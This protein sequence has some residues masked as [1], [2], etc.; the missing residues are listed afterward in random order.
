[1]IKKEFADMIASMADPRLVD[2][3]AII[4]QTPPEV[5]VRL[6][7][8]KST[9]ATAT[10][11]IAEC[12][13]CGEV[14]WWPGGRYLPRRPKFTLDPALHQGVY[15]VQ[16]ASSMIIATVAGKLASLISDENLKGGE[17]SSLPLLWLDACAAPGGKT[18]AAIDA[19]PAGSLVVANEYDYQRAEILKENVVKWG[20]PDMVVS[21]GDTSRFRKLPDLFD[22]VAV[23]APCSGEGM[24]RKDEV[25]RRQWTPALVAECADRQRQ[26]LGNLWE[27]VRPGGYLVYSTCTFNTA[28]NEEMILWL[29]DSYG[30]IPIDLDITAPGIDGPVTPPSAPRA[31]LLPAMRFI[32]GRAKGEGLFLCVLRKPGDSR[33]ALL[34]LRENKRDNKKEKQRKNRSD[35]GAKGI[36][37]DEL[38]NWLSASCR[39]NYTLIKDE[40]KVRAFP[41]MWLPLLPQFEKNLDLICA[42]LEMAD[43]KGN[44]LIPTQ[45]LAMSCALNPDAFPR[46]EMTPT[47]AVRYLARESVAIPDGT[48]KGFVLLT[49]RNLPLGFVKNLG[50]RSN[51][52]YPKEWR[53]KNLG[54]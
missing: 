15:Y 21:R 9:S 34:S 14:A 31:A 11:P 10:Q 44:D 38:R 36:A 3:P 25:A 33:P 4:E 50:N 37:A 39:D 2:L 6:N 17:D 40:S 35:K 43:I 22:V 5:S 53:I 19:L 46:V 49:C 42:G 47:E 27:S 18:T 23:D 30:A 24:M 13:V 16:D 28:E 8:R 51:N 48:P 29:I 41:S 20:S 32:P 54:Q 45:M 26:I 52:L 7:P 12:E 1:M